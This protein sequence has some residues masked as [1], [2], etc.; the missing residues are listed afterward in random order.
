M[1]Q[2]RWVFVFSKIDLR[3]RCHH[4]RVKVEDI[5]KTTFI[6]MN[7]HYEHQVIPLG[8]TNIFVVLTNYMNRIFYPFLDIF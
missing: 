8:V 5:H 2:L 7:G 3:V 4:I 6:T 1:D